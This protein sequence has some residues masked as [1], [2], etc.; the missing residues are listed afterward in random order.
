MNKE[1][2]FKKNGYVI[3]LT[4]DN[5]ESDEQFSDRGEFVVSQKI[6]TNEEYENAVKLSRIY[7]N[8]KY[9]K[10]EYSSS[11]MKEMELMRNKMYEE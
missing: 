11:I 5:G 4:Q 6:Q 1:K 10:S 9:N 7:R 3:H 8:N 2:Y